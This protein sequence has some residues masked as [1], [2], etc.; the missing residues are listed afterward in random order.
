[1]AVLQNKQLCRARG[2]WRFLPLNEWNVD[3]VLAQ[4]PDLKLICTEH[5]ADHQ[6]IGS[7]VAERGRAARQQAGF[8]DNHLVSIKQSRQLNGSLFAPA[9]RTVDLRGFSNISCHRYADATE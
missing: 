5:F 3:E 9:R 8:T 1:M 4:K 7:V 6:V 2:G